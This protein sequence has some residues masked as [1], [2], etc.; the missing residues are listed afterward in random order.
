MKVLI[1]GGAGFIGS[2][3]IKRLFVDTKGCTIVNIDNLNAYY[4]VSL[5]DYRLKELNT[6]STNST[7]KYEF[8]KGD[9]VPQSFF[10]LQ[11]YGQEE[12][13][14]PQ[15]P[16]RLRARIV[17]KRARATARTRT[18]TT[19]KVAKLPRNHANIYNTPPTRSTISRT[20][21]AT[22]QATEHCRAT[23]PTAQ[24]APSSLRIDATAATQGV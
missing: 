10:F 19:I 8:V 7:N 13:P 11:S 2:N 21:P 24:R 23:T 14:Q 15:E 4:D 18:A 22:I 6:I 16:P 1:T 20:S 12:Q 5:K 9:P 3:L 17:K